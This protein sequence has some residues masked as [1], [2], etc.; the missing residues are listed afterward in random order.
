MPSPPLI[1]LPRPGTV[2]PATPQSIPAPP[3]AAFTSTFGPLRLPPASYLQTPAGQAAYYTLPAPTGSPSHSPDSPAGPARILFIHGVQTSAV[4][5]L[6]L[7]RA[8]A[9][10]FPSAHCVLLDLWGHG[11]SATP[12]QPHEPALFHRLLLA[13]LDHL[14]W[15][16]AHLVGYSF[17]GSTAASFAA[18]FPERVE[19]LVLVAP[20]GLLRRSQ[21]S[22]REQGYLVGAGAGGAADGVDGVDGEAVEREARDWVIEWLEGGALV[23]PPDWRER[24][25]RGELVAEAVREWQMREHAGHAASVVGI[26]RDGGIMDMHEAFRTAAETGIRA[27][28]VLGEWDDLCSVEELVGLGFGDVHVVPGVGHGVV[29]ERVAEVAGLIGEFWGGR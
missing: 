11:L 24:V 1:L 9:A 7:A 13:L 16:A 22:A 26:F 15:P 20:A 8:V 6:P 5:L 21:F 2:R 28:V 19:G 27:R 12:L 18:R 3:E 17:G 23:V 25:A 10:R 14:R 29:R 4:G